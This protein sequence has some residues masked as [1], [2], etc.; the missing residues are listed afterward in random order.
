MRA[1]S[2]GRVLLVCASVIALLVTGGLGGPPPPTVAAASAHVEFA[3]KASVG[4]G[5]GNGSATVRAF[6]TARGSVILSLR[7]LTPSARYAVVIRRGACGSLGTQVTAVG[8]FTATTVRRALGDGAAHG[9]A[10]G[11]GP[12]CGGRHEPCVARRGHRHGGALRHPREVPRRHPADLVRAAAGHDARVGGRR[13][14]GLRGPVRQERPVAAGRRP[15]ACVHLQRVVAGRVC[16]HGSAAPDDRRPQGAPDQDRHRLVRAQARGRLRGRR[17]RVR[18]RGGRAPARPPPDQV[19]WRHGRLRV[20]Q[21]AVQR[22]RP[23][24]RAERV[25]LVGRD[26]R[27]EGRR[28]GGAGARGVPGHRV[29]PHRGLQRAAVDRLREAVDQR[30]RGRRR[31]TAALPPPRHRLHRPW[32]GRRRRPDP[33]IRPQ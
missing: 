5:G 11:R 27:D 23:L 13:R 32:L 8:T 6:D 7:R 9:R 25:P 31:G 29:R 3:W 10:G 1:P 24:G 4:T 19:A 26:G 22:R 17:Q 2:T 28:A 21:R 14:D 18:H 30:I 16:E 20:D 15:D 33:G 12:Q